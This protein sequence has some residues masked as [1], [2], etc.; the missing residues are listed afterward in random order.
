[1]AQQGLKDLDFDERLKHA[2][3]WDKATTRRLLAA[4]LITSADND[5]V[6]HALGRAPALERP[7]MNVYFML[8]ITGLDHPAKNGVHWME[9]KGAEH[10][11][12]QSAGEG[13]MLLLQGLM[14]QVARGSF[15]D[16]G[17]DVQP[18]QESDPRAVLFAT[19]DSE[20]FLRTFA[21]QQNVDVLISLNLTGKLTG[22]KKTRNRIITLV[23]RVLDVASNSQLWA[24][25]PLTSTAVAAGR[26]KGTDPTVELVN[27]LLEYCQ[28]NLALEPL[29]DMTPASATQEAERLASDTTGEPLVKL[30]TLRVFQCQG[31]I[32]ADKTVEYAG[33]I[34]GPKNARLFGSDEPL[35]RLDAI[36][37]LLPSR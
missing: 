20:D 8:G 15:G 31:L 4:R 36:A 37:G 7:A 22:T 1:M 10:E 12:R 32:P 28:Q 2:F 23:V 33:R 25:N 11:Y 35:E 3:A 13:G 24:S 9:Q 30:A 14:T 17:C 6:I 19:A 21:A 16:W 26:A 29:S 27:N 18:P 5:D 34:L